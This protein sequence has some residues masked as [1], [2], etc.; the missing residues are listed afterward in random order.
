M[1]DNCGGDSLIGSN[2][3]PETV[4]EVLIKKYPPKQSLKPSSI[5]T[6]EISIT[7]PHPIL[8]DEID[9]QLIRSTVLKMDGAAGPLRLDAAASKCLCTSF[10]T[11]STDLCDSLAATARCI[12]P[13]YV[14]PKGLSFFCCLPS[15]CPSLGYSQLGSTRRFI[16]RAI[17]IAITISKDIQVAAGPLQVCAGHLAV[18]EAAVHAMHHF[19]E[20]IEKGT[21]TTASN[22]FNSLNRQTALRNI[23]HL[24]PSLSKVPINTYREDIQLFVDRETLL[25]QEETT[26]GDPLAKAMYAITINPLMYRLEDEETKQVW[27]ADDATAGGS[28]AGFKTWWN[29]IIDIGPE[30]GYHP[31]A[32]NTWLILNPFAGVRN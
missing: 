3:T 6:P 10:K 29:C 16:G 7:E 24:C 21:D 2:T 14:D 8:F 28:L 4:G 13:C 26:Q 18:R 1:E 17:T 12:C 30:Y 9:E 22:A 27:F 15:H 25:S 5:V 19:Y 11:A 23:H 31:N 20:S 32:S